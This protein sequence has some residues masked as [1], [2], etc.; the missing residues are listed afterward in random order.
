MRARPLPSGRLHRSA[1]ELTIRAI[2]GKARVMDLLW[3]LRSFHTLGSPCVGTHRKHHEGLSG[4]VQNSIGRPRVGAPHR[5]ERVR[6]CTLVTLMPP[7]HVPY[8]ETQALFLRSSLC[9]CS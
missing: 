1:Y 8:A 4:V 3:C 6:A 9:R 5:L 2:R 7:H